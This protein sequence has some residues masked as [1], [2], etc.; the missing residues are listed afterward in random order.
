MTYEGD[1]K[2]M[3]IAPAVPIPA[4]LAIT[5]PDVCGTCPLCGEKR[6]PQDMR[7]SHAVELADS[8]WEPLC[9]SCDAEIAS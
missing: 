2:C 7:E 5:D 6:T 1:N 3:N 4:V 9:A 8:T